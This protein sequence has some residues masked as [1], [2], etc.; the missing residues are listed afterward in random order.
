MKFKQTK[1]ER[2]NLNVEIAAST[3]KRMK[4]IN[5][6][7][8]N[9]TFG[10]F[11]EKRNPDYNLKYAVGPLIELLEQYNKF[12]DDSQYE[13]NGLHTMLEA[14]D[15]DVSKLK[16]ENTKFLANAG[17]KVSWQAYEGCLANERETNMR[18]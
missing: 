3:M 5:G 12:V 14:K 7:E 1:Q 10:E 6:G 15:M 2:A 13:I 9:A 16:K 8:F 18:L 17:G 4:E 11:Q